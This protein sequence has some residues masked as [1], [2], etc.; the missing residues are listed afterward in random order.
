MTHELKTIEPYFTDIQ[1]GVKTFDVR[2][3]DRSYKVGDVVH[4]RQWLPLFTGY[5]WVYSGNGIIK[6]VTYI[7]PGGQFGIEPGYVVL[8]LSGGSS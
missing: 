1:S 6:T 4:F 8:G 2:K 7:L 3:N 5:E